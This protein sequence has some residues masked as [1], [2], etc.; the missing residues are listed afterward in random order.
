MLQMNFD[1][2]SIRLLTI[3][4]AAGF[5]QLIDANRPRLEA[6]LAGTVSRTRTLEDTKLYATEIT[7]KAKQKTYL[8]FLILD[9]QNGSLVGFID[10]KNIDWKIPKGELGCFI[11][12]KYSNKGI[13]TKALR[14]F[15]EF[16]FNSYGFNKL[17][18]RTHQS[19]LSAR[20]VAEN[21]G[22]EIEG[23]IRRDY[24]TTSGELVDLIYY[25]KISSS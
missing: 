24:K 2:F 1:N 6:F 4:D 23:R 17:F 8:P 9:N 25:G 7:E 10:V 20:R 13:L 12:D 11:D 22:F 14:T 15:T 3:E 21:C 19:N 18:L 16:C 5:Y